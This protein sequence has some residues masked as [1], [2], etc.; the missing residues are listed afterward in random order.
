[1]LGE[2]GL[3]AVIQ[4]ELSFGLL[5]HSIHRAEENGKNNYC[6]DLTK[7]KSLV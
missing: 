3:G 1:M 2:H 5:L 6:G 7:R 4:S